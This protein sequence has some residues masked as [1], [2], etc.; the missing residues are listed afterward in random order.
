MTNAR[1]SART[2][3]RLNA[4]VFDTIPD[5]Q[6]WE[7][8][9]KEILNLTGAAKGILALRANRDA[10]FRIP[11]RVLSSPLI[12]NFD[13]EYVE[14]FIERYAA[15]DPWTPIEEAHPPIDPYPLSKYLDLVSLKASE[16]WEWLAPQGISDTIVVK[17]GETEG[18]WVGLNIFF[19]GTDVAV[20]DNVMALLEDVLPALRRAW[21]I[22]EVH[23]LS[24]HQAGVRLN[25]ISFMPMAAFFCR[26]DGTTNMVTNRLR[27]L[28][29]FQPDL[30][31]SIEPIVRFQLQ[32]HQEVL[33]G[34]LTKATRLGDTIAQDLV[35]GDRNINLS[36]SCVTASEDVIGRRTEQFLGVF[37]D[38]LFEGRKKI[39]DRALVSELTLRERELLEYLRD[40]EN[41]I[42]GFSKE[43]GI[44]SHTADFHW[45]NLKKKLDVNSIFALRTF[46]NSRW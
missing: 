1:V 12:V 20:R 2:S 45:R 23:R 4:F 18:H 13:L 39:E 9:I 28:A 8:V 46:L 37:A 40:P 42:S 3:Q 11:A 5:V 15:I 21:E 29:E 17:I 25:E 30:F 35:C 44:S 34:L 43:T 38:P 19:D 7:Q 27:Q 24:S 10:N 32:Q 41:T 36:V 6:N 33:V 16:F 31:R 26:A 22:G 14:S